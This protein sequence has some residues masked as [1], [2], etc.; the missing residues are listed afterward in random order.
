MQPSALDILAKAY[1][2]AGEEGDK[3][4]QARIARAAGGRGATETAQILDTINERGGIQQITKDAE[5]AGKGIDGGLIKSITKLRAEIEETTKR[6]E[7]IGASIFSEDLL[8]KELLYAQYLERAAVAAK[9][10]ADSQSG[11]T[12]WQRYVEGVTR[13]IT[14]TEGGQSAADI[15]ADQAEVDR[16]AARARIA[17]QIRDGK[18]ADLSG[19]YGS[20]FPESAAAK[21]KP[22]LTPEGEFNQYQKQFSVLG[23]AATPAEQLK[24]ETLKLAAAQE[25][26]GVTA[27]T[28]GRALEYFKQKQEETA[29]TTREQL[30]LATEEEIRKVALTRVDRDYTNGYI[31]NAAERA[32]ADKIAT[33]DARERAQAIEVR[34]SDFPQLTRLSQEAG[35]FRKQLDTELSGSLRGI[36]SDLLAVAKGTETA[37]QGFANM[38]TKM[39]D[40]IAQAVLMKTVVGPIAGALSSGLGGFFPGVGAGGGVS[41][42]ASAGASAVAVASALGN[43]FDRGLV[44]FARGGVVDRPTVFRFG[45]GSAGLMGEAGPEAIIPLHRDPSGRLGV[46]STG[47]GGDIRINVQNNLGV[48]ASAREQRQPDGSIDLILDAVEARGADRVVRGRGPLAQALPRSRAGLRG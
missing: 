13:G 5:A 31:K 34:A 28:A 43:V 18:S 39:V 38:S 37:G 27:Q 22:K 7:R 44:P 40:A 9:Q 36:T 32:L 46:R 21:P 14:A 48:A 23:G 4:R 20:L 2:Q 26:S 19:V 47:G 30:G 25:K 10:I 16:R 12:W 29:V 8:Q 1:H 24:N 17:K 42:S 41:G 35:D 15:A 6:A 3:F 33:K 11:M 45:A